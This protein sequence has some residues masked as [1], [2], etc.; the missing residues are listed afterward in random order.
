MK[1][2][3]IDD[4]NLKQFLES[5]AYQEL[6]LALHKDLNNNSQM[7]N[8]DPPNGKFKKYENIKPDYTLEFRKT[9]EEKQKVKDLKQSY[10][11]NLHTDHARL[12]KNEFTKALISYSKEDNFVNFNLKQVIITN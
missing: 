12:L 5:E 1:K 8:L 11:S 3:K 4:S 6:N 2:Q 7:F 9:K 10:K